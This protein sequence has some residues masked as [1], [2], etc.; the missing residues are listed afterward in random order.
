[1]DKDIFVKET[2]HK[3]TWNLWNIGGKEFPNKCSDI[4]SIIT[5]FHT[6]SSVCLFSIKVGDTKRMRSKLDYLFSLIM[7]KNM[8][9]WY[10]R[11]P[12]EEMQVKINALFFSLILETCS[13]KCTI[14]PWVSG[15]N[16]FYYSNKY[17]SHL[18]HLGDI[19]YFDIINSCLRKKICLFSKLWE[20]L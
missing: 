11:P 14:K 6:F 12:T 13:G 9:I 19:W 1:M 10:I 16:L 5:A 2:K 15:S 8:Y 20:T 4:N 17:N 7:C 3:K 18:I